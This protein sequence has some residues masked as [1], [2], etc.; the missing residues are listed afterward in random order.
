MDLGERYVLGP[1]I[2]EG[3][4]ALVYEAEDSELRREVAVKVFR[5]RDIGEGGSERFA[6]EARILASLTHP[7]LL[8]IYDSGHDADGHRFIVMPLVRG[9]TLAKRVADG[10]VPPAETKRIGRTLSD[11]L[12]HIHASGI[13]HRDVKP[14]NVLLAD[15]GRSYLADFG[16]ARAMEGPSLTATGCIVGTAGYLAPEQ[17]EGLSVTAA[18]DVYALGLVL[19]EALTGE[20]AYRGTPLERATANALRP[21]TIPAWLGPGWLQVLR[22]MTAR[23]PTARPTAGEVGV[24]LGGGEDE[25]PGVSPFGDTAE[26]SAVGLWS[27]PLSGASEPARHAVPVSPAFVGRPARAGRLRANRR[28]VAVGAAALAAIAVV[29]LGANWLTSGASGDTRAPVLTTPATPT[30]PGAGASGT[31]Q[32]PSPARAPEVAVVPGS[33]VVTSSDV[34]SSPAASSYAPSA[35]GRCPAEDGQSGNG[36]GKHKCRAGGGGGGDH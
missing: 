17:A 28:P 34:H 8:P 33:P 19:L 25:L 31:R 4:T 9:T 6:E 13:V 14:S 11:A 10:P 15:D 35:S 30:T 32:S 12:S 27:G 29:G 36:H 2:G 21:P 20:R 3:A 18:A 24:L 22:V 23:S 26:L 5:D 7:A 1:L 16:Y